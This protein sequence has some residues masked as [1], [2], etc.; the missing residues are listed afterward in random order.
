MSYIGRPIFLARHVK[1]YQF[2]LTYT[3]IL[4]NFVLSIV[5]TQFYFPFRSVETYIFI[6]HVHSQFGG[7]TQRSNDAPKNQKKIKSQ[8]VKCLLSVIHIFFLLR[9][10]ISS[11]LSPFIHA[12][13]YLS[14]SC[15]ILSPSVL[16]FLFDFLASRAPLRS[17]SL[18]SHTF[19]IYCDILCVLSPVW[20]C[21]YK[22]KTKL[23]IIILKYV[24]VQIDWSFVVG[25]PL[26]LTHF[27]WI[28]RVCVCARVCVLSRTF[29]YVCII[30][31][32]KPVSLWK[33]HKPNRIKCKT[34]FRQHWR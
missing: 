27:Y 12:Y 2:F 10:H 13:I 18:S 3:N 5:R 1:Q 23:K 28:A 34:K 25:F 30:H 8:T 22:Y 24:T 21:I 16:F 9:L 29:L 20:C 33:I 15:T 6:K 32:L 26:I 19:K 17:L 7:Q 31:L 11:L 4:I 14:I